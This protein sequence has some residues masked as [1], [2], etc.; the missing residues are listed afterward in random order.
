MQTTRY[1]IPIEERKPLPAAKPKRGLKNWLTD[2]LITKRFNSPLGYSVL[3]LVGLLFAVLVGYLKFLGA[4]L[5]LVISIGMPIL[6]YSVYNLRAGVLIAI[7]I[8]FFVLAVVRY[9][10]DLPLGLVLDVFLAL[11]F[12]GLLIKLVD[13]RRL[14]G[15]YQPLSYLVL[16]WIVYNLIQVANPW[17][18]SR[19][20]WVYTIR[21]VAGILLLYFIVLYAA[22]S[23][24]FVSNFFKLWIGL[25]FLGCLYGLKQEFLGF[26]TFEH[27]WV[28]SDE[29]R[30]SLI[31]NWGKFRRFSFFSDPT[32][33][34]VLMAYTSLLCFVLATDVLAYWKRF[35]LVGIGMLMLLAMIYSGTR[36]AYAMLPV[37]MVFF[38]VLTLRTK[39]LALVGLFFLFGV[40]I[41]F[42][43]IYSLGPLDS[44]NLNR[45]RSAFKADDASF[46]VRMRNQEY[47]QPYIWSHPLGG[48]LGSIGI[49][50]RRFSPNSPISQFP[51]DSGFVRVAVE[52]GYIGLLLYCS[53]L[54]VMF[55]QGIRNYTRSKHPKIRLYYLALLTVLYS[56][57]VAN[58]PQ[59]SFAIY[60]TIAVFI[61]CMALIIRLKYIEESLT[62]NADEDK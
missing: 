19:L 22:N 59:Q 23:L 16:A 18:A 56:L 58:Y 4:A 28:L 35:V 14:P 37:G 30:F 11:M 26:S 57:V 24:K 38:A 29:E 43:P 12:I 47:I 53:M 50:G 9:F 13:G 36:T 33:F 27:N 49:W 31:F 41:V 55:Y 32:V 6:L 51:P 15:F 10:S 61:V 20:A 5:V 7:T 39:V 45:I 34:G 46:Q 54:F 62:I 3:L 42:S 8:T 2:E 17:A 1:G 25:A 40:G 21:S 60:P 44:N 48:G 52:Q